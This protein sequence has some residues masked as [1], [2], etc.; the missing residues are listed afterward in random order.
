MPI[1]E[2]LCQDCGSHFEKIVYGDAALIPC[3]ECGSARTE[4]QLSTFSVRTSSPTPQIGAGP[5]N[6]CGAPRQGMCQ[7]D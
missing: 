1:F 2:Y 3:K 7:L 6:S 5:C 4:R